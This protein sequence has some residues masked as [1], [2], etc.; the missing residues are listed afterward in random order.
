[1]TV[2]YFAVF[3]SLARMR[4][5]VRDEK[6]RNEE[7]ASMNGRG[8]GGGGRGGGGSGYGNRTGGGGGTT[9][10]SDG[11]DKSYLGGLG[12]YNQKKDSSSAVETASNA[13]SNT[14]AFSYNPQT[15]SI[16]PNYLPSAGGVPPTSAPYGQYAPYQ[17][18]TGSAGY[19][20]YQ[21]P[22]IPFA[23]ATGG[24]HQ[25]QQAYYAPPPPPPPPGQ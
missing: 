4:Y 20:A 8:G 9:S 6:R 23:G 3:D 10:W 18:G 15:N 22:G 1:M 2:A 17:N 11:G 21:Q 12:K 19:Q 24:A 5:R 25:P 14:P 13:Y 16:T 7:R